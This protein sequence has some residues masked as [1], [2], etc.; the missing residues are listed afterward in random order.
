MKTILIITGPQGSGNHL[1]SKI[2]ALHP[3][4]TGW[5]A[6]LD[7]YW[8]GHDQEP[9][10]DCWENPERLRDYNWTQSNWYV[11]SIS[12]P[13]MLNGVPTVPDLHAFVTQLQTLGI[14]VKFAVLGRDRNILRLQQTR[15]RG[16]STVGTALAEYA[17]LISPAEQ[18]RPFATP[19]FLSYE[20]LH[21]YQDK[22]LE[23]IAQQLNFPMATND[24]RLTQILSD[25]TNRKYISQ[26]EHQATDDLAHHASRKRP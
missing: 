17:E 9:F 16:L 15:V 11:T 13:Y 23:M 21:L 4:V 18:I 1:W 2:F 25:D 22:Y 26:V 3:D 10:A 6:L 19:V 20:L 14:R 5:Q 24:P 12:V 7:T 8:I